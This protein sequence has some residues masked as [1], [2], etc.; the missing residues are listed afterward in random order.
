MNDILF[1]ILNQDFDVVCFSCYVWS[2]EIIFNVCSYLKKL[3]SNVV[4]VLGG[5][6]V[7]Q[8]INNVFERSCADIIV[9]G[10]GE[11]A[12]MQILDDLVDKRDR[13][14]KV[15]SSPEDFEY[16]Y[17]MDSLK[18]SI[19]VIKQNKK[20]YLIQTQRGCY[21]GCRCCA[22]PSQC[23]KVH[24]F[25]NEKIKKEL[26]IAKELGFRDIY[27]MDSMINLDKKRFKELCDLIHSLNLN[28]QVSVEL[29]V[30]GI[31][32]DAVVL[33][34]KANVRHIE[35]G[36]QTTNSKSLK[37]IH[38]AF[39]KDKFVHS[40]QI[41]KKN[42][43]S[44]KLD[45]ICGLP[46]DTFLDVLETLKFAISLDPDFLFFPLLEVIRGSELGMDLNKYG[47]LC[48]DNSSRTI[49]QT[50]ELSFSDLYKADM[51]GHSFIKEFKLKSK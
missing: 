51:M 40:Y 7:S 25:S 28:K 29:W 34:K 5:P 4:I 33:L 27:I 18:G 37:L 49:L 10:V 43:F 11:F 22:M 42:N 24:Y 50:R 31:D 26:E 14:C 45:I 39:N 44:I 17:D 23:K 15:Y 20:V 41:L 9:K 35:V 13:M 30:E 38:R 2:I 19:K 8:D 12:F 46:G 32:N 6:E 48:S 36:L 3:N 47:L 1:Y 16:L 21:M